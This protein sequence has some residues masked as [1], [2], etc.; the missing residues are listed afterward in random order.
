MKIH[1]SQ[2]RS[3]LTSS[4][5][6]LVA[7]GPNRGRTSHLR[8]ARPSST[9][10]CRRG[11]GPSSSRVPHAHM[12]ACAC[13]HLKLEMPSRRPLAAKQLELWTAVVAARGVNRSS[14]VGSRVC[15][16][17]PERATC[18]GELSMDMPGGERQPEGSKRGSSR[19]R[20]AR[21]QVANRKFMTSHRVRRS[22]GGVRRAKRAICNPFCAH[23]THESVARD[24]LGWEARTGSVGTQ[25]AS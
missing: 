2:C 12:P 9:S 11:S 6:L 4:A 16:V 3:A 18:G 21:I 15:A 7:Q 5:R 10:A 17:A 23:P 19:A 1:N 25:V 14:S 8:G 20:R 13:A 22:A 24:E